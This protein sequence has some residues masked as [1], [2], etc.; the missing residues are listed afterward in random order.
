MTDSVSVM[1]DAGTGNVEN[2]NMSKILGS[3]GLIKENYIN[4]CTSEKAIYTVAWWAYIGTQAKKPQTYKPKRTL[5]WPKYTWIFI[6]KGLKNN[7]SH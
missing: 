4:S 7:C 3:S 6:I 5:R 1:R 2:A